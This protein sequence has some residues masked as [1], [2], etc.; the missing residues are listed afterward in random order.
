MCVCVCVPFPLKM[1]YLEIRNK[2]DEEIREF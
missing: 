1:Y 2:Y